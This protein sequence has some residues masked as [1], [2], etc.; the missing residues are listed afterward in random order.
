[1]HTQHAKERRVGMLSLS[2]V[3]PRQT[4]TGPGRAA[5]AGHASD[6]QGGTAA[7]LEGRRRRR[8]LT[9]TRARRRRLPPLPPG[10]AMRKGQAGRPRWR[11]RRGPRGRS[12]AGAVRSCRHTSQR[13]RRGRSSQRPQRTA[14]RAAGYVQCTAARTAPAGGGQGPQ[15]ARGA[16]E[17]GA[18]EDGGERWAAAGTHLLAVPAGTQQA[19]RRHQNGE[20]GEYTRHGAAITLA[21]GA[22]GAR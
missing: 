1:M 3:R 9:L 10:R 11:W 7:G 2:L 15:W 18:E 4:H 13:Q 12:G 19:R 22:G 21:Q 14:T 6:G 20:G 5:A 17:R 16:G 8:R